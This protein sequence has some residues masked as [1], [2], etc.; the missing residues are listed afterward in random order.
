[1]QLQDF[2]ELLGKETGL[3]AG[4]LEILAGFPPAPIALPSSADSTLSSLPIVNG[5]TLLIRKRAESAQA[6]PDVP[7]NAQAPDAAA[8]DSLEVSLR[9]I[10]TSMYIARIAPSR[11]AAMCPLGVLPPESRL[12]NMQYLPAM[13]L[14][15]RSLWYRIA[16]SAVYNV[17]MDED[18]QLA[19]AIAASLGQSDHENSASAPGHAPK[20]AQ[21]GH[22][23]PE[24]AAR[25]QPQPSEQQAS[26]S[27]ASAQQPQGRWTLR[28]DE[29][30]LL[31][32][33]FAQLL[34]ATRQ[35]V[36]V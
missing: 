3:A 18:E 26:Q 36:C 4:E 11:P 22:S 25:P 35:E 23:R 7:S 30:L 24:Q 17:Q 15:H 34:Q 9:H 10:P 12:G 20:P 13:C 5:D 28:C 14:V 27:T 33:N 16:N 8:G 29:S 31:S 2:L 21:N 32:W 1:M 6:P 19:R